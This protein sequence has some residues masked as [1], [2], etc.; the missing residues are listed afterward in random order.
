MVFVSFGEGVRGIDF[1]KNYFIVHELIA[2]K[3]YLIKKIACQLFINQ[4]KMS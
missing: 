2:L 1:A 4:I 3:S